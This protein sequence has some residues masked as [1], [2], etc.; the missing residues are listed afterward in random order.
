MSFRQDV[1]KKI[2]EIL[3]VPLESVQEDA[4]LV[5]LVA[6]SFV[7]IEMV[8]ELQETFH[9]RLNQEDLESVTT[10]RKLLDVIE[11]KK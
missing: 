8:I 2:S 6:E 11:S 7:L 1:Q 9:I 3:N 4:A 10:V 5:D